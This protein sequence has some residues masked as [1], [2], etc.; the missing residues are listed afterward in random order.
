MNYTLNEADRKRLTEFRNDSEGLK[1]FRY[2]ECPNCHHK[3]AAYGKPGI[4]YTWDTP[5]DRQ[6]LC[7]ALMREGK[8][9]R[10]YWETH[11]AH[12]TQTDQDCFVFWLLVQQPERFCKLVSIFL[13]E[14]NDGNN[15]HQNER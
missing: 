13:E 7:E 6:A 14:E 3:T 1:S 4:I 5:D 15:S 11:L 12:G 8:W 9:D 10:F 2:S